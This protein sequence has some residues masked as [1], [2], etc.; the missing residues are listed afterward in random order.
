M[1]RPDEREDRHRMQQKIA[2]T[3]LL[4]EIFPLGA[5]Q[6]VRER[7]SQLQDDIPQGC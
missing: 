1:T 6:R 7:E 2:V 3:L 5:T 4:G